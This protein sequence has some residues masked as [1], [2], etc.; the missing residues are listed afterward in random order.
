MTGLMDIQAEKEVDVGL[1]RTAD[2][3]NT[4]VF[5]GGMGT[6]GLSWT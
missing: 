6:G 3:G 2:F 1:Y 5:V 4:D